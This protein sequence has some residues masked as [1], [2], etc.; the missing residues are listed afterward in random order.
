MNS[1]FRKTLL[2]ALIVPFA[3]GVQSASAAMITDWG[4]GVSNTFDNFVGS[5]GTG[6]VTS[7]GDKSTLSWGTRAQQ[8]SVS[9]TDV[10]AVSGLMTN[11]GY[12]QG[13]VISHTNNTISVADAALSSFDLNS[14]LTLTPA[15]PVGPALSP[16]ATLFSGF[17]KETPN[18]SNCGFASVSKCDD[19]FT[20]GNL[21]ALGATVTADG[22]EFATT[23]SLDDYNYTVFLE[24]VGL[25]VL[26]DD[27]CTVAGAPS[28]CVGLL[29][30]ENATNSFD[31][32]FRISATPISVPEPGTLAL[33]G[34]GIAGLG[35][36]RRK[37][38]VKA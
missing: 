5:T 11:G 10:S 2:A 3:F 36:A 26:N 34:M 37:K 25:T 29:T 27:T 7:S 19:I 32:R 6:G 38:A 16:V 15:V 4:Y 22:F 21:N 8:S 23:F 14:M 17:F 28:G 33:L 30:Q 18:V 9:V 31:A 35:L 13:G 20:V 24:L 1:N 12:V